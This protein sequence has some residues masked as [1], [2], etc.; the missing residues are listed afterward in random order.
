MVVQPQFINVR[1]RPTGLAH[2]QSRPDLI[3]GALHAPHTFV[4]VHANGQGTG[5]PG[6][7]F[8]QPP[9]LGGH[10]LEVVYD[11][12][13]PLHLRPLKAS[14]GHFLQHPDGRRYQVI[15][16]HY[17]LPPFQVGVLIHNFKPIGLLAPRHAARPPC[18][19]L[20]PPQN[21]HGLLGPHFADPPSTWLAER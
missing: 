8:Q 13:V 21:L 11:H 19:G 20:R 15:H 12:V 10:V 3:I 4:E 17:A 2:P 1:C 18:P 6:Q 16:I 9:V 7:H 5:G 14:L